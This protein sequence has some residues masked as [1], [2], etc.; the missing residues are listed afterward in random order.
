[1][2]ERRDEQRDEQ[3]K[4]GQSGF[5]VC[6]TCGLSQP[7]ASI[8]KMCGSI[9]DVDDGVIVNCDPHELKSLRSNCNK[10]L[11]KSSREQIAKKITSSFGVKIFQEDQQPI[12]RKKIR[13]HVFAPSALTE[14]EKTMLYQDVLDE[15]FGFG[16]LGPLLRDPSIV[17]IF[18]EAPDDIKVRRHKFFSKRTFQQQI[19]K[20]G[21]LEQEMR[22]LDLIGR[23]NYLVSHCDVA[24][25]VDVQ[26][27]NAA[28][29][30][31]HVYRLIAASEHSGGSLQ[32]TENGLKIFLPTAML[33]TVSSMAGIGR[34][35]T[36]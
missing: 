18:V 15:V 21:E 20:M 3:R 22:G 8:C 17:C 27:D 23:V 11:M 9:I 35:A 33:V 13:T 26:F 7:A 2:D 16:T 4:Q 25:K 36:T 31:R 34:Y 32:H 29:L 5:S 12:V 30:Q 19:E 1:M 10:E 24:E 6:S 28:Q 14:F